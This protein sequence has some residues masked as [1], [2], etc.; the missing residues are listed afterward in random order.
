VC[1]MCVCVCVCVCDTVRALKSVG[2]S[3]PSGLSLNFILKKKDDQFKGN[4]KELLNIMSQS[5]V[6]LLVC[7][8]VC[9]CVCA[10]SVCVCVLCQCA[11]VCKCVCVCGG[12]VC[13]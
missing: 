6:L 11:C 5:G 1:V 8:C 2:S 3:S 12:G 4:I 10:V 13:V 9:V 7:V